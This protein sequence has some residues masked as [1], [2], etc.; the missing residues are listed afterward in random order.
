MK[1]WKSNKKF[2]VL[3]SEQ[4]G[5]AIDKSEISA[6][7]FSRHI[8]SFGFISHELSGNSSR[9][10]RSGSKQKVLWRHGWNPCPLQKQPSFRSAWTGRRPPTQPL[11]TRPY[12]GKRAGEANVRTWTRVLLRQETGR[13]PSRFSRRHG[14]KPVS[15]Q[16]ESGLDN[17]K[18][19]SWDSTFLGA[20]LRRH[21][22]CRCSALTTRSPA[23][24]IA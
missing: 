12:A 18:P 20:C 13:D 3:K 23:L 5:W 7:V 22:Q 2:F 9:A 11:E 15:F 6:A 19:S 1:L 16:S 10:E 14:W 17:I 4:T 8:Q 24:A 21:G